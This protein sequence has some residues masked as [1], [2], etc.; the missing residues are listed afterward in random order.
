MEGELANQRVGRPCG[1]VR[2]G[3]APRREFRRPQLAWLAEAGSGV[4]TGRNL[5]VGSACTCTSRPA[6]SSQQEVDAAAAAA[7]AA[8]SM[9][10]N[11]QRPR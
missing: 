10:P 9:P 2:M 4:Q 7:S 8:A 11:T 5:E 6:L 3:L 1:H